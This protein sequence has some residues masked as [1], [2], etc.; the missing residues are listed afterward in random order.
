[1]L[2]NRVATVI[3]NNAVNNSTLLLSLNSAGGFTETFNKNPKRIPAT[4]VNNE[5]SLKIES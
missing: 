4:V 2:N 3:E 5:L 1:M